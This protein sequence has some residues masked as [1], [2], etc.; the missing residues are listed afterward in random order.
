MTNDVVF[1]EPVTYIATPCPPYCTLKPMHP[2]DNH[3]GDD[4][5]FRIHG[6]PLFGSGV[7]GFA[8]E[9]VSAPGEL[10]VYVDLD[11]SMWD[12][13]RLTVTQLRDISDALR[14]ATAWLEAQS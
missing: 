4:G 8:E 10:R 1:T 9:Y 14:E 11:A 3:D 6:G 5:D 13:A 12:G 2:V 7:A